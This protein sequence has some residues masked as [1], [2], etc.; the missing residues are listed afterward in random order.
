MPQGREDYDWAL[1]E[2]LTWML[3]RAET[4]HCGRGAA[5]VKDNNCGGIR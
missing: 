3:P 5:A 2:H 4:L 1:D